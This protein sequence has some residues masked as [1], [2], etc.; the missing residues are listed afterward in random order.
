MK[1]QRIWRR[2]IISTTFSFQLTAT[3]AHTH[4][5]IHTHTMVEF[6][7]A[8]GISYSKPGYVEF[9]SDAVTN[10]LQSWTHDESEWVRI[11]R[12]HTHL[13]PIHVLLVL[14][15][16][17]FW[18]KAR[19]FSARYVFEVRHVRVREAPAAAAVAA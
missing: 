3:H 19:N 6:P 12:E 17:L 5:H 10:L 1:E 13:L 18:T 15:C 11:Q 9:F 7:V 4:T 8:P 14:L 2:L 16:G